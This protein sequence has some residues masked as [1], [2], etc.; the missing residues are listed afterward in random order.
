M[1]K[2]YPIGFSIPES[3][4][5][6]RFPE[7][8]KCLADLI[9]QKPLKHNSSEDTRK[10]YIYTTE[11]SY[12]E[13]YQK[14]LFALTT[15]KDGWDC[16]RHY[17]IL[18]Q[19]CLP[20]FPDIA[21][22]PDDTMTFLPKKEIME[23]N[24][25]YGQ[26]RIAEQTNND[27]PLNKCVQLS[28]KLLQYTKDHLTTEKMASY[29]LKTIQNHNRSSEEIRS[30]LVLHEKAIYT[31]QDYLRSLTLHGLKTIL[32]PKC[33]E[34]PKVPYLYD[35]YDENNEQLYGRG[36]T[37]SR[38]L[39]AHQMYDA[40][41]EKTL[42]DDIKAHKYDIIIYSHMEEENLPYYNELIRK[43][44]APSEIVLLC[45]EDQHF[46]GLSETFAKR[47]HIVFVRELIKQKK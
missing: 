35:D 30:V 29:V 33:H 38:N 16:L 2:I 19:G 20:Y 13:D 11:E 8:S 6:S 32:G 42:L 28:K 23:A 24:N 25:L 1:L 31:K 4:I 26:C 39:D 17:E 44:Y 14:S 41:A 40:T 45:G 46:P 21:D 22:C 9:P 15:K 36:F 7:K 5:V 37:Y 34:S 12:Y 27:I 18:A 3:K 43:S 10:T 47:G